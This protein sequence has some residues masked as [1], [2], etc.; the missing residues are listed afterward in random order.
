MS[1]IVLN[2]NSGSV[3]AKKRKRVKGADHHL[4]NEVKQFNPFVT[5]NG[6]RVGYGSFYISN[7]WDPDL[8][9]ITNANVCYGAWRP[10]IVHHPDYGSS[11]FNRIG[12]QYFMKYLRFKGYI[13]VGANIYR[14]ISWRLVLYRSNVG[15]LFDAATVTTSKAQADAVLEKVYKNVEP[16][17]SAGGQG[18]PSIGEVSRH[19]FYKKIVNVDHKEE[20]SRK[21]IASGTIPAVWGATWTSNHQFGAS[22][23][24]EHG[25]D[26]AFV[27]GDGRRYVPIDVKVTCNDWIKVDDIQYYLVLECDSIYGLNVTNPTTAVIIGVQEVNTWSQSCLIFNLFCRAYFIDP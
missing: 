26:T 14:D 1:K 27:V 6:S 10:I 25:L 13:W 16:Y 22:S 3:Y 15:A 9:N 24:V 11:N 7:I 8:T 18:Q 17:T 4:R 12:N 19:N 23:G 5:Q 2:G 21:V 20:V